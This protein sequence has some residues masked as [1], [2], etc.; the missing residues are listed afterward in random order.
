MTDKTDFPV[1]R[2]LTL[3]LIALV[4]L[5]AG[6]GGWAVYAEISGAI[7]ASGRIEVERN[8]QIVQH[9]DGGVVAEIEVDEGDTVTV[10][11]LLIRLDPT[12]QLSELA[13]LES[14]LFEL[15]ARRGRLE[16]E[17]AGE[18]EIVFDPIL[19]ERASTSDEVRELMEGQGRLFAARND[20]V[21]REIEQ[22]TKRRD[23]ITN[24]VEGISAQ[25][26]ALGRQEELI[27]KELEGQQS[28]LDRGLAQAARVLALER[29]A[30][31]LGG[32]MGE[33]AAQ[34]AQ[35]EGRMTEIDIEILKLGTA[36]REDAIARLRDQQFQEL[37]LN[38]RRRAILEQLERM[39][40]RSPVSGIVYG[41]TVFTPRSVIRPAEPILFV[42]PQDRPL[43]IAAQVPPI[44]ID[45]LFVGQEVILR[46]SALDQRH[47]SELFGKVTQI[48]A[49]AFTD[50]ATRSTFYRAEIV[51]R[52]GEMSKLPVGTVLIPGM[53]VEA[54]IKTADRTPLA[55]LIKPLADYFAKAFRES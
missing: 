6:F 8:R 30:A 47:T 26:I 17:R 54:F 20:S 10:D 45:E 27:S 34:K 46:F 16:A 48:S 15:I 52:D 33:L 28:L 51:L 35:A 11:Q 29:E 19:I 3:G 32:V 14:Q 2:P 23:Q 9:P 43:L 25:Q 44:H 5:V 36:R 41:L 4:V 39:D 53:P 13:I 21:A 37:E 31:R 12:L 18:T 22:L 7:V 55:Y 42:V 1:W 40:I 24:Q 50:E 49:D 38:E